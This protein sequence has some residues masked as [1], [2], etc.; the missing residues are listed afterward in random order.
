MEELP[1]KRTKKKK[2]NDKHNSVVP[3]VIEERHRGS[4]DVDVYDK[5]KYL[6]KGGFARCYTMTSRTTG[7]V[8][9][10]KVVAKSSLKKTK[11]Q[12][13]LVAEIKI[14][15]HLHNPNVV[16]FYRSFQD[17]HNV[18]ILLELCSS[19][20]LMELMK[21]RKAYEPE[22]HYF[23]QILEAVQYLHR[24]NVIHDLKLGNL[25]L[26]KGLQVK[27]G[28][29]GL[30]TDSR[31]QTSA[32]KPFVERLTTLHKSSQEALTRLKSTS[33]PRRHPFLMLI[34]N[35]WTRDVKATYKRISVDSSIFQS[36]RSSLGMRAYS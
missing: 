13:K 1:K 34:G 26:N 8:Y 30:S 3:D 24:N 12:Q 35:V 32:R 16:R 29:M 27:L 14:H 19:Q 28:D 31:T 21:R 15:Q 9:A 7:A 4:D 5:G 23:L 11:A 20:S 25:F 6:G 17:K 2:R 22:V 10:G 33:G 36:R 18:Y